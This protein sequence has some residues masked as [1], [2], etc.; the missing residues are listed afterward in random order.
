MDRLREFL[1]HCL[2]ECKAQPGYNGKEH[3][4]TTAFGA[5]MFYAHSVESTTERLAV[6][7]LWN[8]EYDPQFIDDIMKGTNNG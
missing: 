7:D 4:W 6:W 2:T 3:Y 5:M 8:K 1:D